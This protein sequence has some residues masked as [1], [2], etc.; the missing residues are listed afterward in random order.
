MISPPESP[1]DGISIMS[2]SRH[3]PTTYS[4]LPPI[5][6]FDPEVNTRVPANIRGLDLQGAPNARTVG[7]SLESIPVMN[8][9]FPIMNYM[10]FSK[11]I[12]LLLL[13][14]G[15]LLGSC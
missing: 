8:L 10:T 5:P 4:T 13:S 15:F 11:K 1:K 7:A 3:L 14:A 12:F 9:K 2:G 6:S